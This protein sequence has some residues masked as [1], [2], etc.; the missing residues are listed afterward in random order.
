MAKE[1]LEKHGDYSWLTG[2][3]SFVVLDNGIEWAATYFIMFLALFFIGAGK[4]ASVDHWL[5]RRFRNS[6]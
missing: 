4:Y 6:T 3:G 1:I 5:A 2:E